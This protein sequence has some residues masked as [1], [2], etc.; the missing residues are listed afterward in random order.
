MILII[1]RN[2]PVPSLMLLEFHIH[3]T[4]NFDYI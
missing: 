3:L 1:E 2:I 4:E